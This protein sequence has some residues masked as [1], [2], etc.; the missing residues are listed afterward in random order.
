MKYS[1]EADAVLCAGDHLIVM[2]ETSRL[3][4]LE[5]LAGAKK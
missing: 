4:E 5:R 1:P 2:G 3:R